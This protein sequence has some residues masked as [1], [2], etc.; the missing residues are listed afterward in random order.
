M[1]M[2][3]AQ[4]C[5]VLN[6]LYEEI[7]ENLDGIFHGG[8]DSTCNIELDTDEGKVNG[9]KFK[10]FTSADANLVEIRRRKGDIHITL[11]VHGSRR[12]E[13]VYVVKVPLFSAVSWKCD[14]LFKMLTKNMK[15]IRHAE[16][17]I[18][19]NKYNEKFNDMYAAVFPDEINKILLGGNDD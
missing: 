13:G 8:K 3:K 12:L 10:N 15:K 18:E 6:K 2:T 5:S 11:H 19:K 14:K 9:V 1:E 16:S 4:A 7:K 17:Q